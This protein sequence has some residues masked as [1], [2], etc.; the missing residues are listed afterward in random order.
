MPVNVQMNKA[1]FYFFYRSGGKGTWSQR[2]TGWPPYPHCSSATSVIVSVSRCF[3]PPP[4]E[5]G[6]ALHKMAVIVSER[7]VAAD[8]LQPEAIRRLNMQIQS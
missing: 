8:E 1:F 4:P 3:S 5:N 7:P 2:T 6:G